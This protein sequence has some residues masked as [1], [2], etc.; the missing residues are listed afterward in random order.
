MNIFW[1]MLLK[2]LIAFAFFMAVWLIAKGIAALIPEGKWRRMLL[3]PLPGSKDR[4]RG[5]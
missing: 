5:G 4:S 2:P 3:T 1:A